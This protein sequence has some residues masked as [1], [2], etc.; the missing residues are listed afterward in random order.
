MMVFFRELKTTSSK[1]EESALTLFPEP[2]TEPSGERGGSAPPRGRKGP[3]QGAGHLLLSSA[4]Q[5]ES[6][7]TDGSS[8]LVHVR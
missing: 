7:R 3:G 5:E 6:G 8:R 1:L 4:G 2:G